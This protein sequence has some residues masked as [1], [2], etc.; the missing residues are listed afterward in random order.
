MKKGVTLFNMAKAPWTPRQP[1][2][3]CGIFHL[4]RGQVVFQGLVEAG[5]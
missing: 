1:S 5:L 3:L 4:R 2:R